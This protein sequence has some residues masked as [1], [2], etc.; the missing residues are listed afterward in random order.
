MKLQKTDTTNR[1]KTDTQT[2]KTRATQTSEIA[3]T[4]EKQE[5]QQVQGAESVDDGMI[6]RRG[7][8][9]TTAE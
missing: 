5:R 7:K 2:K 8:R 4:V 6:L 3:G 1:L 9:A